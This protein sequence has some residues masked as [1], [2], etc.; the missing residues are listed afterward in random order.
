MAKAAVLE[1]VRSVVM[2]TIRESLFQDQF[3]GL[4]HLRNEDEDTS[5]MG[6]TDLNMCNHRQV[7][8]AH[9]LLVQNFKGTARGAKKSRA[10][11]LKGPKEQTDDVDKILRTYP[12]FDPVFMKV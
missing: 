4:H 2:W 11:T 1:E 6:E 10:V 12:S 8:D 7:W 9:R 5:V 3:L